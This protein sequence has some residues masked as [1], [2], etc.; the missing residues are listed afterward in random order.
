MRRFGVR[1][2][3]KCLLQGRGATVHNA[4]TDDGMLLKLGGQSFQEGVA[5]HRVDRRC[6]GLDAKGERQIWVEPTVSTA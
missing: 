4:G 2:D 1:G 3:D 6:G 5:L